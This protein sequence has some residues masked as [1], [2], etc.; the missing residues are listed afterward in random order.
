MGNEEQTA[1][2]KSTPGKGEIR[3]YMWIIGLVIAI[4]ILYAIPVISRIPP[5]SEITIDETGVFGDSFG[6][7]TALFS[8]LA[9]AGMM[10]T[11]L[12]QKDQ[13]AL[14]KDELVLTR[15]EMEMQRKQMELQNETLRKQNFENTFFELL[16]L[17]NDITNAID[18]STDDGPLKGRDCFKRFYK[19]FC[20]KYVRSKLADGSLPDIAHAEIAYAYCYDINQSDLGHYFRGLYNLIKFVHRSD[21]IDRRLY[22]N[23]VR[24]QLSSYELQLLFF[25]C[26]SPHGRNDFKPLV[27][28]YSLLKAISCKETK[29]FESLSQSYEKTAFE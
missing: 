19:Q 17:Q 7:L 8:G 29:D 5:V 20:D 1:S 2:S 14:Q 6:A 18:I 23:L 15:K 21:G 16:R 28:T 10:I 11:V 13:L 22:T 25:N 4:F 3:R 12:M 9:F 24:A 26:L 27:N